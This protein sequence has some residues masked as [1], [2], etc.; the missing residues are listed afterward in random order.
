MKT[1]RVN[2]G[3]NSYDI[4]IGTNTLSQI[5]KFVES[6]G[7][8]VFILS[9]TNVAPIFANTVIDSL[10]ER[11]Y[12]CK[13]MVLPAGEPTKSIDSI[14]PI[15]SSMLEFN[16]TRK[17]LVVTLGGGVIGDLGGFVASTY[18]RGVD[19]VQV[20][21]SLLAQ[22]ASSVGGK[23]AVDLPEGKNLVGSFYQPKLV[24]IDTAALDDLPEAYYI[25]GMAEIIK[26]GCI[27]DEKLFSL[28]ENIKSRSEFMQKAEEIIYTCCD[29]KRKV[30]EVDE[31]DNGERMLLNFGHTYG[32]AIEKYYNFTGYSH[33]Q[34]VAIGM[35]FISAI[36]EK[37]GQSEKGTT[38]RIVK[39]LK[40]Y[41][42]PTEDKVEVKEVMNAILN[43]K[44]NFGKKLHVVLLKRIG[45]S[46]TYPT[47]AEYFLN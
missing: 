8:K 31:K 39:I 47:N 22:V 4:L 29:I 37:L 25:D 11:G 18:L 45:E 2:L 27:K 36:S 14:A 20:P 1:L 32:H 34:A 9:D 42:L 15:Y 26:Y 35:A 21:T 6:K 17:D 46:F 33:G 38:A 5:G 13:L 12:E 7:G 19:F 40:Q 41:G 3:E 23:V 16:L 44:K 10:L 24:F 43:D 28:L 30:V